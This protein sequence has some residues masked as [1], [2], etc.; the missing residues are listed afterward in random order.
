MEVA[1]K[2]ILKDTLNSLSDMGM[3]YI[4]CENNCIYFTIDG[5]SDLTRGC[6]KLSG[7]K[8]FME[9][10]FGYRLMVKYPS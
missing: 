5:D 7:V 4:K 1:E 9:N 6:D 10:Q 2:K 3:T 8:N